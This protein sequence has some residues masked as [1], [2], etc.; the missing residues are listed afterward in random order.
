MYV[1]DIVELAKIKLHNLPIAKNE[2]A[3]IKFIYLGVAELYRRFNLSIKSETITV[4]ENLALYEL[5]NDDVSLLLGIYDKTGRELKQTDIYDS[6]QYEYKLVNYRSFLLHRPF[7]GVLYTAYLASPVVFK[8]VRDKIDLPDSMIDAL[9]SYVAYMSHTTINRDNINEASAYSQRFDTAC[10]EL[11]M[12]G[13][14]IPLHSE[15]LA[16]HAKGFV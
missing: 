12:Q 10:R 4:N 9:L 5:R 2:D 15:T 7:N 8:D 11:E 3:L 1:Q 6:K 16:L 14:K 13:Y